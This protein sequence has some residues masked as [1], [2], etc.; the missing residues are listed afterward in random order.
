MN[1][2]NTKIVQFAINLTSQ[3]GYYLKSERI[4][5]LIKQIKAKNG[6]KYGFKCIPN[7]ITITKTILCQKYLWLFPIKG[8]PLEDCQGSNHV[9]FER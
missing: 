1:T 3:S 7:I 6:L 8:G 2:T 9:N 4:A 5:K